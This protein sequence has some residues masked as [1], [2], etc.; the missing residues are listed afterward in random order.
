GAS[1][2]VLQDPENQHLNNGHEGDAPS[3]AR[4]SH[5]LANVKLALFNQRGLRAGWRFILFLILIRVVFLP[6]A[7]MVMRPFKRAL[8]SHAGDFIELILLLGI[9]AA[10]YVMARL[11][12]RSFLDYGL[13]DRIL[14]RHLLA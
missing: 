3:P 11:E 8:G 13:R 4:Q 9:L 10:T 12:R 6:L 2:R 5:L 7:F 1:E 14:L